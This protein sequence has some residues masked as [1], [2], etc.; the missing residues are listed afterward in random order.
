MSG[1]IGR[2]ALVKSVLI[3]AG[4]V[5]ATFAA[6][7]CADNLEPRRQERGV[8]AVSGEDAGPD[9]PRQTVVIEES[10]DVGG[11]T[12]NAVVVGRDSVEVRTPTAGLVADAMV[13]PGDRVLVGDPLVRIRRT[14]EEI[15][16]EREIV[17][18]E[19]ELAETRDDP[20]ALAAARARLGALDTSLSTVLIAP[21]DGT[22]AS[23]VGRVWTDVEV[24]DVIV[25]LS[26]PTDT[27]LRAEFADDVTD[28]VQVGDIVEFGERGPGQ[29]PITAAVASIRSTDDGGTVMN[30]DLDAGAAVGSDDSDE[31]GNSADGAVELALGDRLRGR[32]LIQAA[33]GRVWV[34]VE[35]IH[36][37]G[38]GSYLLKTDDHGRLVRVEPNFGRRT[39]TH[40]SATGLNVGDTLVLP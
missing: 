20:D 22:V 32:V 5:V 38:R 25:R 39:E 18:L 30:F 33:A 9:S 4:L 23:V 8:V 14:S 24:D 10:P 6:G 2:L 28:I 37:P 21:A 3:A 31:T 35:S 16:L 27:V 17:Q 13:E 26:D 15:E 40:V 12:V 29:D 19:I 36:R 1:E 11:V 34:P 7:G